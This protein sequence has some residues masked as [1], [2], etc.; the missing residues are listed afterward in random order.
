MQLLYVYSAL[1]Q[2]LDMLTIEWFLPHAVEVYSKK[3][4][5]EQCEHVGTIITE[6]IVM[7]EFPNITNTLFHI[8]FGNIFIL[9]FKSQ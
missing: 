1:A 3:M 9:K 6:F 2:K 8:L 7:K 4:S 5:T